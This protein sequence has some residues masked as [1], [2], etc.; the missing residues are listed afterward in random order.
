MVSYFGLVSM[1]NFLIRIPSYILS[2]GL[3][4]RRALAGQP[5]WRLCPLPR[6]PLCRAAAR[7]E[8]PR[9]CPADPATS[10]YRSD[11]QIREKDLFQN[12]ANCQIER[13]TILFRLATC[14]IVEP[15]I[16]LRGVTLV[17][18]FLFVDPFLPP[19]PAG[20][21]YSW[22]I[23]HPGLVVPRRGGGFHPLGGGPPRFDA[24]GR[25]PLSRKRRPPEDDSP[26]RGWISSVSSDP[27]SD[28]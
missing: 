11:T 10:I 16:P 24:G 14:K 25:A 15:Q 13:A 8:L 28:T 2:T 4:I 9:V 27:S 5:P 23:F 1:L 18:I 26:R 22:H 3:P 19:P 21:A 6:P 12:L 17:T 7:R 20:G